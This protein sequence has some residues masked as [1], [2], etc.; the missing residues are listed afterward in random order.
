M[1]TLIIALFN[2]VIFTGS[3]SANNELAVYKSVVN[4]F[5]TNFSDADKVNWKHDDAF[6]KASFT[7]FE[8]E[9]LEIFYSTD[10]SLIGKAKKVNLLAIPHK[11]IKAMAKKYPSYEYTITSTVAFTK[12]NNQAYQYV[13]LENEK[14]IVILEVNKAG[15]IKVFQVNPK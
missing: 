14:E 5:C 7:T 11:A 10:G 12:A 3:T 8:G 9:N 15:K 6:I 4:D 13:S 2:L 1:K